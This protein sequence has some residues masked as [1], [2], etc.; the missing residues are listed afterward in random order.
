MSEGAFLAT[1][2]IDGPVRIRFDGLDADNHEIEL[3][4]LSKSLGGISRIIGVTANFA[5]TQKLNLHSDALAVRVMAQPPQ[6]G[7]FQIMAVVK[8]VSADPLMTTV[9]GGLMVLL[10][11]YVFKRAAGQKEEMRQ[12]RGALD[13][14]IKQLGIRDQ[15]T[16]DRL[17]TTID[18]MADALR[19]AAKSAVAPIGQTASTLSIGQPGRNQVV[20][21]Q[22]EKEAI[23]SDTP[24][25]V[26]DEG[27]FTVVITELDMESGA[28]K[29]SLPSEPEERIN[30]RITD[31]AFSTPNNPYALAMAAKLA[32]DV[33]AKP[34]FRDGEMDKLFISNTVG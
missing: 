34:T 22:A 1:Q 29:V 17:L 23:I 5:A 13:E 7:C 2:P 20:V 9:V 3:A 10:V 8:W 28:C 32:L 24:L 16:V 18:R 25:E 19:P 12:L 6:S 14:A 15:P 4:S 33:R 11:G 21:G 27:V 30:G 26:G 31:P